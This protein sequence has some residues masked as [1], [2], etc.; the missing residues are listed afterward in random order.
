MA[1]QETLSIKPLG[2]RIVVLPTEKGEE[3]HASGMI[4]ADTA[5]KEKPATGTVVAVGPG[6]YEDGKLVPMTVKVGDKILFSKYGYDDVKM[7][8]EEYYVLSEASV[9]AV[10]KK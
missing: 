6:R 7:N 9:L 3:K 5:N 4:L 10:L 8:G 2:D 1:K